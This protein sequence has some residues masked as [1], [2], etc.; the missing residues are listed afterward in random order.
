MP[1]RY[2]YWTILAGGLP[3]SFRAAS[4]EDLLPTLRRLQERHPDATMKW[5]ARGKLW[6]SPEAAR[7]DAEAARPPRGRGWRP[8][9]EHR[10]PREK[11][12]TAKQ[13]RNLARRQER[14]KRRHDTHKPTTPAASAGPG[15]PP[16]RTR[17]PHSHQ[18]TDRR[19]PRDRAKRD[20]NRSHDLR[21]PTKRGRPR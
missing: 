20:P 13:T 10:D 15:T 2:A 11:Y 14:F 18:S 7:G 9:G 16:A 19:G 1:P 3:T 17:P 4:R 5:F 6:L 12:A 8:G 21:G